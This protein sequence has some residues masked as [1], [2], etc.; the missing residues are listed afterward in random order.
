MKWSVIICNKHDI[1]ELPHKLPNGLKFKALVI[2]G[3]SQNS[4]VLSPPKINL[5]KN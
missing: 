2:S 4:P 1:Y 3:K 5:A